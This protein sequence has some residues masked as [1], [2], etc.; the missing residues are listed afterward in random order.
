MAGSIGINPFSANFTLRYLNFMYDKFDRDR[1]DHTSYLICHIHNFKVSSKSK[2]KE[3][4]DFNPYYIKPH[5][6]KKGE[7]MG[8]YEFVNTFAT[9]PEK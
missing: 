7:T 8:F 6:I 4:K 9:D 2:M 3:A 5:Q 1:W